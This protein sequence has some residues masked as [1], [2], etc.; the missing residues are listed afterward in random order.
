MLYVDFSQIYQLLNI[1][2]YAE[3]DKSKVSED[4]VDGDDGDVDN[5]DVDANVEREEA[6]KKKNGF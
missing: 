6:R 2:L 5:D 4:N 1:N 3:V